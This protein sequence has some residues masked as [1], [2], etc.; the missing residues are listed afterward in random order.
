MRVLAKC[1]EEPRM[2]T[3]QGPATLRKAFQWTK[4]RAWRLSSM[5]YHTYL[6]RRKALHKPGLIKE[7]QK[8]QNRL[9]KGGHSTQLLNLRVAT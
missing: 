5:T 6:V 8:G 4:L 2:A 1:T 7:S 3:V 9:R